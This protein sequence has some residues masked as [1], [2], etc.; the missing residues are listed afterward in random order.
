MSAVSV[1]RTSLFFGSNVHWHHHFRHRPTRFVFDFFVR[2]GRTE[3]RPLK[4]P[5]TIALASA[6]RLLFKIFSKTCERFKC[7]KYQSVTNNLYLFQCM[8][9]V[10]Y[11]ADTVLPQRY[12]LLPNLIPCVKLVTTRVVK[13]KIINGNVFFLWFFYHGKKT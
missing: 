9:L 12:V 4:R 2:R 7:V 6:A 5:A 13:L 10:G 3:R 1:P 8:P 11:S